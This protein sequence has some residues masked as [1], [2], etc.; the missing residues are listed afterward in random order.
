MLVII[1]PRQI[2]TRT[3]RNSGEQRNYLE[4]EFLEPAEIARFNISN[5]PA[6]FHNLFNEMKLKELLVA[7][8]KREF[9]GNHF[10]SFNQDYKPSLVKTT[11]VSLTSKAA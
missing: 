6:S 3:D 7:L 4:F 10:W 1:K 9:Q 11:P 2:I 5:L 8:E